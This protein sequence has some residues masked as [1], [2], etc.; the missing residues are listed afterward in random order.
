MTL[1]FHP[2]ATIIMPSG[3]IPIRA[4]CIMATSGCQSLIL[5]KKIDYENVFK[6]IDTIK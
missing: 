1:G 3:S 5:V 4:D 2:Q 6:N